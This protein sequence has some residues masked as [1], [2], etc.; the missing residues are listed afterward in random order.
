MNSYAVKD[1]CGASPW[2]SGQGGWTHQYFDTNEAEGS[3]LLRDRAL[4]D[5]YTDIAFSHDSINSVMSVESGEDH[6][7]KSH[8]KEKK[9]TYLHERCSGIVRCKHDSHE[10]VGDLCRRHSPADELCQQSVLDVRARSV[11]IDDGHF[12]CGNFGREELVELAS[13]QKCPAW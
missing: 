13:A 10:I 12:V 2:P 8:G 6:G 7:Y 3:V 4:R 9:S 11:V 1:S 5:R